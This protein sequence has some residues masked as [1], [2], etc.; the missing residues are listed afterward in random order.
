MTSTCSRAGDPCAATVL[1]SKHANFHRSVQR[2]GVIAMTAQPNVLDGPLSLGAVEL[3][4]K[5]RLLLEIGQGGMATVYVAMARGPFRVRK[6][7]VLKVMRK[8]LTDDTDFLTMFLEEARLGVHLNHPNIVNTFEVGNHDRLQF[9]AMEYLEGQSLHALLNRSAQANPLPFA[10]HL[11]IIMDVLAGLQY[12]YELR[13]YDGSLLKIVHRDVSPHNIFVTYEGQVKLLDFGIAKAANS[14]VQTNT[15]V[16]KGK[17]TYMAPEQALGRPVDDRADVYSVGVMLWEIIAG[18][19]RYTDTNNLAIYRTLLSNETPP[20][21]NGVERGLPA[22]AD[23][24]AMKAIHPDREKRFQSAAEF[25]AALEELAAIVE[26]QFSN[27]QIGKWLS[28]NFRAERNA[29]RDRLEEVVRA[30]VS[31]TSSGEIPTVRPAARGADASD[32]GA[33]SA[34]V[35]VTNSSPASSSTDKGTEWTGTNSTAMVTMPRNSKSEPSS[36]L[37]GG[38]GSSSVM[39]RVAL[40]GA[41]T[42]LVGM[43][44]FGVIRLRASDSA[45]TTASAD[46]LALTQTE[47]PATDQTVT[48]TITATPPSARIRLDG[49]LLADNPARVTRPADN[50]RHVVVVEAPNHEP[51]SSEITLTESSSLSIALRA[52]DAPPTAVVT[53]ASQPPARRTGTRPV[54]A[55]TPATTAAVTATATTTAAATNTTHP[56]TTSSGEP[57]SKAPRLDRVDPWVH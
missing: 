26:P 34:E 56:Q 53:P 55:N 44:M 17:I 49:E 16:V 45:E 29:L 18:R 35:D 31:P 25:H 19:R 14:S 32:S 38:G 43:L 30:S 50:L 42:A 37:R 5:Y 10:G 23:E 36:G 57:S 9:I 12:A 8:N 2:Y 47:S 28:T 20:S 51:T 1:L 41:A 15:G 54:A 39:L 24:I 40:A 13:D 21:C 3:A 6:L 27:R 11:R 22:L 46:A 7:C 4:D 48:L 33:I 52:L